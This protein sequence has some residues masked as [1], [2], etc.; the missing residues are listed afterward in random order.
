MRGFLLGEM[1]LPGV[2]CRRFTVDGGLMNS[3]GTSCPD[4]GVTAAA[5]GLGG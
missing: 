3:A 5:P 1:E 4:S 2:N